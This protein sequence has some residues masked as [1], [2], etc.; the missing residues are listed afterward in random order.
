MIATPTWAT[1]PA[2]GSTASKNVT[3]LDTSALY[4]AG[5]LFPAEHLN[6]FTYWFYR[7]GHYP[8]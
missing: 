4:S 6:Q 5:N 8:G 3:G 7:S 2:L 1:I